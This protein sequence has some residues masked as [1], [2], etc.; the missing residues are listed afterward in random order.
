MDRNKLLYAAGGAATLLAG[1]IGYF[2]I[3]DNNSQSISTG[4]GAI[5]IDGDNSGGNSISFHDK[6][7][8]EREKKATKAMLVNNCNSLLDRI[9]DNEYEDKSTHSQSSQNLLYNAN[10]TETTFVEHFGADQQNLVYTSI[11]NL[12]PDFMTWIVGADIKQNAERKIPPELRAIMELQPDAKKQFLDSINSQA[13]Q[14]NTES[15]ERLARSLPLH[16]NLLS[17]L[18]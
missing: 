17:N 5:I 15:R 18:K 4:D 16:C 12:E 7:A 6:G 8:S 3:G 9:K 10:V 2:S 14:M 13:E 1:V 11:S